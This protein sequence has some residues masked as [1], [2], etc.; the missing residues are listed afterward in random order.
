MP[1]MSGNIRGG[2]ALVIVAC[3]WTVSKGTGDS[4][5]SEAEASS[6]ASCLGAG[7]ENSASS[8]ENG[9]KNNADGEGGQ[10]GTSGSI[11]Q[12]WI[13]NSD[14]FEVTPTSVVTRFSSGAENGASGSENGTKNVDGAG[15]RFGT[16]GSIDH[17]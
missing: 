16:S 8:S 14:I 6:V 12:E 15:G 13:G 9:T 17:E 2:V 4:E 3:C 5:A 1:M 11:D 7:L 10:F